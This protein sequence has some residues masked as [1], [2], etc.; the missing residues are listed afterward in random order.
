MLKKLILAILVP[1]IL[2]SKI[3]VLNL[4]LTKVLALELSVLLGA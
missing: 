3:L 4:F 1:A 2:M